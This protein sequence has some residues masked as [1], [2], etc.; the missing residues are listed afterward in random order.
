MW[1][2]G[3]ILERFEMHKSKDNKYFFVLIAPN[4]EIICI[5][6]TYNEKQSCSDGIKSVKKYALS[7]LIEDKT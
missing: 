3:D 4:N 6:E 1:T 7:A 2:R 5:S